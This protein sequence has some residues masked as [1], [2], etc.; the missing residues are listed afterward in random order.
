[1][2]IGTAMLVRVKGRRILGLK[3][4][5]KRGIIL[6]GGK[7]EKGETYRAAAIR[8]CMEEA[9]VEVSHAKL[10]FQGISAKDNYC[11]TY[12]ATKLIMDESVIGRDF[13]SGVVG[14]YAPEDFTDSKYAAY[15]DA[16]FQTLGIIK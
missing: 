1:M 15:Y 6:P 16:L 12:E 8:E 7:V 3:C 9:E 10:V 13:G 4:S 5:K 14:L 2:I 11:F